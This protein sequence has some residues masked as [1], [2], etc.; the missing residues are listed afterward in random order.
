MPG[1]VP[2]I[3]FF[4]EVFETV[5]TVCSFAEGGGQDG[6][7]AAVGCCLGMSP[8]LTT[9]K[10]LEAVVIEAASKGEATRE[11]AVA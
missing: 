11:L 6:V 1:C 5:D 8:F 10:P 7:I 2:E 3:G 9:M 4:V